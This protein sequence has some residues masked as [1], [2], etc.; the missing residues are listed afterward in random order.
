MPLVVYSAQ[1]LGLFVVALLVLFWLHLGGWLLVLLAA[2]LAWALS[3]VLLGRSRDRAAL[4]LS[5][6]VEARR[7]GPR[8]VDPDA[9]AEDAEVEDAEVEDAADEDERGESGHAE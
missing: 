2:L 1:R 5:D 4:W 9:A 3:Y 6:R 8:V 7:A